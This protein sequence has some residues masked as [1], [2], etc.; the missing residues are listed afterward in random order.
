MRPLVSVNRAPPLRGIEGE[1]RNV[2]VELFAGRGHHSVGSRHETG[3]RRQR[4]AAGIFEILARLE[5]RLF[6]DHAHAAHLLQAA[7]RVGDAP[8]TC[9]ELDGFAPEIGERNGIGPK[10]V[11]VLGGGALGRVT[12]RY[13]ALG[14]SIGD[15]LP[16]PG[17]L[18][19]VRRY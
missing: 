6:A 19:R 16:A 17:T 4:D 15:P 1:S 8:M 12:A 18:L 13:A 14:A 7:L 2:D 10:E 11:A 9:F 5:H 3:S